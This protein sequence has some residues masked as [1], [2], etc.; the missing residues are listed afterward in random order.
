MELHKST[1]LLLK[2]C[3]VI[4]YAGASFFVINGW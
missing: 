4:G 3:E 1:E 2:V